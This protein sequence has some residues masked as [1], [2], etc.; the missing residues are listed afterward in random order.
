[1]HD[2]ILRLVSL[3]QQNPSFLISQCEDRNSFK[4]IGDRLKVSLST[5]R[6][7]GIA[8]QYVIALDVATKV[9]DCVMTSSLIETPEIFNAVCSAEVPFTVAT[10]YFDDVNFFIS[11]SN[12]FIAFPTLETNV[13]SM[14]SSKYFFSSLSKNGSCKGRFSEFLYNFLVKSTRFLYIENICFIFV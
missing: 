13:E 9:S 10:A 12:I 8:P 14:T 6:K 3:F 11:S 5:S 7:F 4:Q 2:F 1:M